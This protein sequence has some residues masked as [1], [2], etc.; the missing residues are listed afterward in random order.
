VHFT[1]QAS[2]AMCD[3]STAVNCPL[4]RTNDVIV[5]Q[6]A[7]NGL[8]GCETLMIVVPRCT[9]YQLSVQMVNRGSANTPIYKTGA[10]VS[11]YYGFAWLGSR[12]PFV[13]IPIAPAN[14]ADSQNLDTFWAVFCAK[15]FSYSGFV[16]LNKYSTA[17]DWTYSGGTGAKCPIRPPPWFWPLC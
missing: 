15:E 13:V 5:Q 6:A 10:T 2:N 9:T 17:L 4:C 3:I 1:Y 7:S 8:V 14:P 16:T 12:W 11:I